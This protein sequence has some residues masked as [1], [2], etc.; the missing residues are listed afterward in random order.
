[1][2]LLAGLGRTIKGAFVSN[3]KR[4]QNYFVP[5]PTL[6]LLPSKLAHVV[7]RQWRELTVTLGVHTAKGT[8][9]NQE[10]CFGAPNIQ[11]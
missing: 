11:F 10:Q 7:W 2:T 9:Y 5:R 3:Y 4:G 8:L 6:S 1:M